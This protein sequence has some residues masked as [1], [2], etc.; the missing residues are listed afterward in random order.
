MISG[1]AAK[2]N[3]TI[4]RGLSGIGSG[5]GSL[6]RGA[7]GMAGQAARAGLMAVT[8]AAIALPSGMA[9]GT[10]A[11]LDLGGGLTDLSAQTG[12]TISDL[13]VMRQAFTDAGAGAEKVGPALNLM[14]RALSGLNED[15]EPT[16]KAFEKLGLSI[17]EL[18]GL[19]PQE[20][21]EKIG[22]A[23]RGI[24]DPAARAG[25]ALDMF[26]RSGGQLLALFNDPD[27]FAN[28]AGSVGR[29]AEIL[30]KN[31]ALF[32][33]VSDLLGHAGLKIQ[34]FFVGVASKVAPVLLPILERLDGLDFA[35]W[36]EQIGNVVA[37]IVQA[38]GDGSIGEVVGLG[39]Q[40]AAGEWI[41]T[42]ASYV[43]AIGAGLQQAFGSAVYLLATGL[44]QV[45]NPQFWTGI[46]QWLLGAATRF[47]AA[48]LRMMA[49]PIQF[50]QAGLQYAIEGAMAGL[51]KIPGLNKALGLDGFQSRGFD[52]ILN[53]TQSQPLQTA[54]GSVDDA[55][56]AGKVMMDAA[57][58]DVA[59]LAKG[60]MDQV[61]GQA[62]LIG[63][64]IKDGW[65]NAPD[66][67]DTSSQR[68]ALGGLVSDLQ[69]G[70]DAAQKKAAETAEFKAF[71]GAGSDTAKAGSENE[72]I[73]AAVTSLAKIGGGGYG[74]TNLQREANNLLKQVAKNTADVVRAMANSTGGGGLAAAYG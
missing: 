49:A 9:V 52:E 40:I 62:G 44:A 42:M 24:D 1:F 10:K 6:L 69:A 36:G 70:V 55:D 57:G 30:Q 26:G 66:V 23:L 58:P 45:V 29:Q 7:A 13:V 16:N 19:S 21:F 22:A 34:G 41:N 14:Q 56:A 15:G 31:A 71:D 17:A 47:G 60:A 48:L 74:A 38:F 54:G 32:D 4:N 25:A 33:T 2:A 20:Q 27:A 59:A 35:A 51:A 72:R 8:A 50:L 73:Q 68:D 53:E 65:N 46:G 39:L 3:A 12:Q 43:T 63:Q 64:K 5:V 61:A 11:A 37:L 18:K 67:V 28:A